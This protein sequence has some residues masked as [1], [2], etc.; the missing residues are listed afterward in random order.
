MNKQRAG[1][2]R[3]HNANIVGAGGI[4]RGSVIADWCD[5]LIGMEWV[6]RNENKTK[7]TRKK[8]KTHLKQ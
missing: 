5:W 6:T 8:K 1:L 4:E 7:T 3:A 2:V